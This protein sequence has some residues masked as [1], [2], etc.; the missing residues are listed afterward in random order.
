MSPAFLGPYEMG[1]ITDSRRALNVWSAA[2]S[3]RGRPV[4]VLIGDN[5]PLDASRGDQFLERARTFGGIDVRSLV[6]VHET[7]V[8]PDGAPYAVTDAADRGSIDRRIGMGSGVTDLDLRRIVTGA[9]TALSAVHERNLIYQTVAPESLLLV[10]GPKTDGSHPGV[11]FDDEIVRLDAPE[12][13]PA[14]F[15]N[16]RLAAP[17]QLRGE[18]ATKR[19]DVYRASATIA[20]VAAGRKRK[21][22]EEWSSVLAEVAKERPRAAGALSR[23]LAERA[24]DRPA[25]IAAWANDL[26]GTLSHV[27]SP[28][29]AAPAAGR[30]SKLL[31]GAAAALLV[32][33]AAGG[34]WALGRGGDD[35]RADVQVAQADPTTEPVAVDPTAAPDPTAIPTQ[36][37]ADPTAAP[38][39]AEATA[40]PE[41]TAP[42]PTEAPEPE[43]TEAPA[44]PGDGDGAD[45]ASDGDDAGDSADGDSDAGD[46]DDGAGDS[47]DSDDAGDDATD[48]NDAAD[49]AAADNGDAS[50]SG[51]DDGST[52]DADADDDDSA[53]DAPSSDGNGTAGSDSDSNGSGSSGSGGAPPRSQ[54]PQAVNP[55]E[56]PGNL[57]ATGADALPP[58]GDALSW[59]PPPSSDPVRGLMVERVTHD[60]VVLTYGALDEFLNIYVGGRFHD[61]LIPGSDRYLLEGLAPKS[62]YLIT[63]AREG[64][65]ADGSTT[66]AR[67]LAFASPSPVVGVHMP[68]D[69]VIS[70]VTSTTATIEWRV[71]TP[72]A[73]HSLHLDGRKV[74]EVPAGVALHTFT[75]LQPGMTHRVGVRSVLNNNRSDM[76]AF[77]VTTPS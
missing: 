69:V 38:T 49:D 13:L 77:D 8:T 18:A 41:P 24:A 22:G 68:I 29:V 37:E 30:G 15:S 40:A 54:L 25:S 28:E 72:G 4:R 66:C 48:D 19:T 47:G 65:Q 14:D 44:A 39:E 16:D 62:D 34:A 60:A 21:P 70:D 53:A 17:E 36:A 42:E 11:L 76:V 75:G 35:D 31:W 57:V 26:L 10:A 23:G 9:G 46:S 20:E 32:I 3:R 45:D 6:S 1:S 5:E 43:P 33:A 67:T 59:C 27:G 74:A 63:V 52:G 61:T 55:I 73:T 2:D 50:G 56:T 58:W 51:D 71:R 64:E 7:G 12:P